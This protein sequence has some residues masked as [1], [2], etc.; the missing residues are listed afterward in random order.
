MSASSALP[1]ARRSLDWQV[2]AACRGTDTNGFYLADGE[3]AKRAR[4]REASAK[5]VCGTC[6]VVRDCL[7]WALD[8]AE[9]WGVWGG[10]T[11]EERA[12]L[13]FGRVG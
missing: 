12:E 11:P 5:A 7:S 10:T 8:T 6:P 4:R 1:R 9:R 3:R 2:D 13:L